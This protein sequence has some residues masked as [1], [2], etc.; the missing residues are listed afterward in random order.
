MLSPA[1]LI[2]R[3]VSELLAGL[4]CVIGRVALSLSCGGHHGVGRRPIP[5]GESRTILCG[6][7]HLLNIK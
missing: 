1:R 2:L 4:P 7:S 5:R 3:Q 6:S